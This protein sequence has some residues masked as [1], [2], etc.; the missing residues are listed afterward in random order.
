MIGGTLVFFA[1]VAR[2]V[3]ILV[4]LGDF[5]FVH[6]T[7]HLRGSDNPFL[8]FFHAR[9]NKSGFAIEFPAFF[10]HADCGVPTPF[11]SIPCYGGGVQREHLQTLIRYF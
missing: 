6:L 9:V 1:V 5:T 8:K 7:S 11:R 3:D 2:L 10:Q 4:E